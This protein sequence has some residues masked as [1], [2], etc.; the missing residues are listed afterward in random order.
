MDLLAHIA[1]D[2]P[3]GR[4]FARRMWVLAIGIFV[5]AGAQ[6]LYAQMNGLPQLRRDGLDWGYDVVFYAMAAVLYGRGDRAERAGALVLGA[7][8][9]LAGFDTLLD[10]VLKIREPRA[11]EPLALGFSAATA[12]L[13]GFI[14]LGLLLPFRESRN[15]LVKATWLSARNSLLSSVAYASVTLVARLA[16]SRTVEYGLDIFAAALSFQAAYIIF[17]DALRQ[18]GPT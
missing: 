2:D 5:F 14:F 13:S 11:I 16:T 6:V 1:A 3:L 7:V 9:A 17:R 12:A 4:R 8:M 18:R 15:P 10:L